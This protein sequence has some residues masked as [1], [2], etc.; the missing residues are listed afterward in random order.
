MDGRGTHRRYRAPRR[1][2]LA[3]AVRSR[4]ASLHAQSRD[5]ALHHDAHGTADGAAG[6]G[7]ARARARGVPQP[8]RRHEAD[9]KYLPA[10]AAPL[11]SPAAITGTVAAALRTLLVARLDAVGLAVLRV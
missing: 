3:Q 9:S 10:V 8:V 7:A 11:C 2:A 1:R 6:R 4:A 5:A